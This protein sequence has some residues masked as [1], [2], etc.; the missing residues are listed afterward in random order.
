[1]SDR[2]PDAMPDK[3]SEYNRLYIHTTCIHNIYIRIY[4]YVVI[5]M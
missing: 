3:M 5:Y 4:I 2:V 1:M